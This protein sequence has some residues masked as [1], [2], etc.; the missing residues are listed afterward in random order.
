M[1]AA[2]LPLR[3]LAGP[4]DGPNFMVGVV[5]NVPAQGPGK[6]N[7][8]RLADTHKQLAVNSVRLV[9]L[10]QAVER[11]KGQLAIDRALSALDNYLLIAR[12]KGIEPLLV[13][14]YG[15]PFYD[16]GGFPRS[17]EAQDAF[18]RY[19]AFL[20][21]RYKGAVK[22]YELW[23]E[24][25][26]G[27]GVPGRARGDPDS[28]TSL[29]KKVYPALKAIDP[30]IVMMAGATSG[31]D[32]GFVAGML[33][34]GAI[35]A[36]DAISVHPYVYPYPPERALPLLERLESE[37]RRYSNGR[38]VPV[39]ATE[40]G[41]VNVV[42][43]KGSD[44]ATVSDYLARAFLL[45]PTRTFM[46]GV[47]WYDRI[48]EGTD[49]V[50]GNHHMGLFRHDRSEKP[51][52]CALRELGK[53]LGV[54]KPVSAQQQGKQVWVAKFSGAQ[55]SLFAIWSESADVQPKVTIEA[56]QNAAISAR[57]IC[58]QVS[59]TGDG[60]PSIST[61]I[62]SSPLLLTTSADSITVKQ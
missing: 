61:V 42:G 50:K 30:E 57:G 10:W 19:A 13:L 48:D 51:A 41:W 56:A 27:L 54:Y 11:Q 39:Y 46:K 43:P 17:A 44:E 59:V 28:Y 12:G 40:I 9:I 37:A 15:N 35:T 22:H 3:S 31:V 47:W 58:R 20:A 2:S 18:V 26:I 1:L 33:A 4:G 5:E 36:M 23:N 52:V 32:F 25:D 60:T 7:A 16:A 45:F 49:P 62:T 14:A 38:D 8:E 29:L 34:A 53:L 6:G 24:Y 21:N 55:G